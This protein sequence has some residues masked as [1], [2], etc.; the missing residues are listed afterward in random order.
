MK[1]EELE[2]WLDRAPKGK[3]KM[4]A[5]KGVRGEIKFEAEDG[6]GAHFQ[7]VEGARRL[8]SAIPS[9]MPTSSSFFGV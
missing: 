5:L 3:K 8:P 1:T 9:P 6:A 7:R 2:R 4:P